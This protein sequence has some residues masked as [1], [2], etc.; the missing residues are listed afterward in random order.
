[1][2]LIHCLSVP[3]CTLSFSPP[4]LTQ[5][6]RTSLSSSSNLV[7]WLSDYLVHTYP[8]RAHTMTSETM[9]RSP[10]PFVAVLALIMVA[11]ATATAATAGPKTPAVPGQK[12]AAAVMTTDA[13]VTTGA[14]DG[15]FQV[16][17]APWVSLLHR[18]L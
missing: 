10:L 16:L 1:M 14:T 18:V 7:D 4:F 17:R 3:L 5:A 6:R 2:T 13:G 9:A 11:A 12:P 15:A 8:T